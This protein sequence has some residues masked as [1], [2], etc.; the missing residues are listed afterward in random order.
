M[1]R[2]IHTILACAGALALGVWLGSSPSSASAQ[3]KAQ[4]A[5]AASGE[6]GATQVKEPPPD[7]KR[8]R[9]G[10]ACKTDD[11]CQRHHSCVKTGDKGVCT[12]P[13]LPPGTVT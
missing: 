1:S 2:S 9:A 3:S 10:D 7:P 6:S 11:E 12:A 8:K 5:I 4:A 13:Q